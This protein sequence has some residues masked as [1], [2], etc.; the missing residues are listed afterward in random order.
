MLFPK[1][2]PRPRKKSF[3]PRRKPKGASKLGN[4]RCT[5]GRGHS[6][7]SKFERAVCDLIDD[8]QQHGELV[9]EQVEDHVRLSDA[10]IVYVADFKVRDV[11]E[12]EVFWIEAKGFETERWRTNKKL[13]RFYGP[14]KL[15]IWRG[16]W[17]C[18]RMTDVIIPKRKT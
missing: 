12:D 18:P 3:G 8:R 9:L 10:Q 13:W 11:L 4:Q 7:R 14:G 15:E 1:P 17:T 5:C 16:D 2:E 6:H